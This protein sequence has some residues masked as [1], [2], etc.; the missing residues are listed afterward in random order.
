MKDKRK[1]WYGSDPTNCEN[2]KNPLTITF[3]DGATALGG[4]MK[5]CD[6][7]HNALGYGLGV[8]KGQRYQRMDNGKWLKVGS[9]EPTAEPTAEPKRS[10]FKIV[11]DPIPFKSY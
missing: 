11:S 4:W 9:A 5:L 1:Y 3:V 10:V 7:C 2:C 8:G 6:R